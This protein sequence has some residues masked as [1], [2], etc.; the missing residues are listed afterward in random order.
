MRVEEDEAGLVP[1]GRGERPEVGDQASGESVVVEPGV[2]RTDF[3]GT[4]SLS[5]AARRI[6]AYGGTPAHA[7]LE[8]IGTANHTDSVTR[9]RAPP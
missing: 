3:L 9:S 2:F 5:T 7:T 1:F 4:N 8:W 6:P